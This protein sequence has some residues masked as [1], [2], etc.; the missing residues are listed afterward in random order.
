MI[1]R[2]TRPPT[3][4]RAMAIAEALQ[5][6]DKEQVLKAAYIARVKYAIHRERENLNRFL[7]ETSGL[8]TIDPRVVTELTPK[9]KKALLA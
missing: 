2:A 4:T 6:Q 8:E 3:L 5:M 9:E 1:E 7:A